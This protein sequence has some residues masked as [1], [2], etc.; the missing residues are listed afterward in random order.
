MQAIIQEPH[1][2]A[3]P[4]LTG[5]ELGTTLFCSGLRVWIPE[6]ACIEDIEHAMEGLYRLATFGGYVRRDG[7]NGP[8]A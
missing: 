2:G 8:Q 1:V 6:S 7:H 4:D 3:A 5:G